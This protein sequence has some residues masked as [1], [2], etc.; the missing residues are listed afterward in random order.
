MKLICPD[1]RKVF[2][3]KAFCPD[4]GI[5]GQTAQEYEAYQNSLKD[6]QDAIT[7]EDEKKVGNEDC[8][9][10][11]SIHVVDDLKEDF[12]CMKEASHAE[13]CGHCKQG[14]TCKN[15]CGISGDRAN[16]D[17]YP[18]YEEDGMDHEYP[19]YKEVKP[20]NVKCTKKAA[21]TAIVAIVIVGVAM[22]AIRLLRYRDG[23]R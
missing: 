6:G 3:G 17:D 16:A 1:C 8:L 5:P 4:C 21:K 18:Y 7:D 2:E 9:D 20:N 11:I 15:E 23:I 19:E 14:C 13:A 22:A 12:G 10:E